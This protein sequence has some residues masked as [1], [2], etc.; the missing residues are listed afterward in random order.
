MLCNRLDRLLELIDLAEGV[1]VDL[2]C[3]LRAEHLGTCVETTCCDDTGHTDTGG[4]TGHNVVTVED[5]WAT[6]T[7]D[8][9]AEEGE[10]DCNTHW[11]DRSR[12]LGARSHVRAGR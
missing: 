2:R 8:R 3:G 6:A 9:V 11:Y 4:V 12:H 5:P 10:T 7:I 1:L